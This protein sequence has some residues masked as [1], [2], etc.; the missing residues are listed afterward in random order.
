MQEHLG[1][2]LDLGCKVQNIILITF[3]ISQSCFVFLLYNTNSINYYK[4]FVLQWEGPCDQGSNP[5]QS[6]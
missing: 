1:W 4:Y 5:M 3:F 6:A 2:G